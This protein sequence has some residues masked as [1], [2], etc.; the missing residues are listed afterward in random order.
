M[1]KDQVLKNLL[2]L[3]FI[4]TVFCQDTWADT[5]SLTQK[6]ENAGN[7]EYSLRIRPLGLVDQIYG[8]EAF[9]TSPTGFFA[10]PT[11]H[12]FAGTDSPK[13]TSLTVSEIGIKAG[14]VFY[15]QKRNQGWFIFG[16]LNYYFTGVTNLNA[17][18]QQTFTAN[19][20]QFGEGI[21]AGYQIKTHLIGPERWD[22]RFGVGI[23]NKDELIKTFVAS[24]GAP[25]PIG[26]RKRLNPALEFSLGYS[27]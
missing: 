20:N 18:T 12:Y 11:F 16:M 4:L 17:A 8:I 2:N 22:I 19:I 9:A 27:L 24:N 21:F 6:K 13:G 10:G 1:L 25:V 7:T 5:Q 15:T 23:V 14:K 26:V 3:F